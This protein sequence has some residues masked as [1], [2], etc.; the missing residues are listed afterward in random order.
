MLVPRRAQSRTIREICRRCAAHAV[1]VVTQP[2]VRRNAMTA[3]RGRTV[4]HLRDLLGEVCALCQ[5]INACIYGK[6]VIQMRA[7]DARAAAQERGG[8]VNAVPIACRRRWQ[9]QR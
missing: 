1:L 5:D 6:C 4:C 9:R 7:I 2:V 8:V 3:Q